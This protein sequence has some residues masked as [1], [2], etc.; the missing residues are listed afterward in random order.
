M[1]SKYLAF[2]GALIY[3][4]ITAGRPAKSCKVEGV[5]TCQARVSLLAGFGIFSACSGTMRTGNDTA[6][7]T[8]CRE[9]SGVAV[10]V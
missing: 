7:A 10:G 1:R 3:V 2:E 8:I 4:V 5:D 9:P 6:Y